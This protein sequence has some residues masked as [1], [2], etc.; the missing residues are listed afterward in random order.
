[1][2]EM[3]Q[4]APFAASLRWKEGKVDGSA[5]ISG[6]LSGRGRLVSFACYIGELEAD[7]LCDEGRGQAELRAMNGV[8]RPAARG[9][10]R[11]SGALQPAAG[12]CSGC[13][14]G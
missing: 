7:I 12:A 14:L 1:M 2:L 4:P 13:E 10:K 3:Y 8:S 5:T 6:W 9:A 11:S